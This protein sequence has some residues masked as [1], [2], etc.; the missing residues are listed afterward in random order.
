MRQLQV[1]LNESEEN[2][3][4]ISL[5]ENFGANIWQLH[6][7]LKAAQPYGSMGDERWDKHQIKGWLY[8]GQYSRWDG[9]ALLGYTLV[10][11]LAKW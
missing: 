10:L 6:I 7:N 2:A 5:G 11:W 3:S 4:G 8:L 1:N 9:T